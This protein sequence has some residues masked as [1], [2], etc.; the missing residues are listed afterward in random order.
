M[1]LTIAVLSLAVFCTMAWKFALPEGDPR[2]GIDCNYPGR[3]IDEP[4]CRPAR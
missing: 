2:R 3:M 1:K 4:P